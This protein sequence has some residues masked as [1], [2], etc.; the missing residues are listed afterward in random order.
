[1]CEERNDKASFVSDLII[2]CEHQDLAG[3]PSR[4]ISC[5]HACASG[6]WKSPCVC[7]CVCKWRCFNVGRGQ[8]VCAVRVRSEIIE[9]LSAACVCSRTGLAFE[10]HHCWQGGCGD[11]GVEHE[12]QR[13]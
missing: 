12:R 5:H 6:G 7:E 8:R 10:F 13:W 9:A 11:G 2:R 4:K 3:E 1:M